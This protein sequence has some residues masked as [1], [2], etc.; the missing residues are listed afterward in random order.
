M[1]NAIV[2]YAAIHNNPF[3]LAPLLELFYGSLPKKPKNI[4]LSYLVLPLVLYP[5]SRSFL[6]RAKA[7]SS[8]RTMRKDR[9]RFYGLG[10]RVAEYKSLTNLCMQHAIDSNSIAIEAD[11]SIRVLA[12]RLDASLCPGKSAQAAKKLGVLFAPYEI[13]AIY[14]SLGVK[15]L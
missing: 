5:P 8:I 1:S 14:R 15:V 4:L 11:L 9:N 6:A 12:L 2:S 3:I 10:E 7:T 13:P